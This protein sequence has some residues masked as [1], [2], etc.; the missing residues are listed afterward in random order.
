[1]IQKHIDLLAIGALLFGMA[2]FGHTRRVLLVS[3]AARLR[4]Q[5]QRAPACPVVVAPNI[6]L[7]VVNL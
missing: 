1:L 6:P 2:V 3:P 5:V 7:T 4:I